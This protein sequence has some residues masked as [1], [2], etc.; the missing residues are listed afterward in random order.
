MRYFGLNINQDTEMDI[1]IDGD[2]KLE[3]LQPYEL[4]RV[5]W[6]NVN[7]KLNEIEMKA[8][9]SINASIG[10]LDVTASPFCAQVSS[11]LQQLAPNATVKELILQAN[12]LRKLKKLEPLRLI[13]VLG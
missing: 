2:D 3:R 4:S 11:H 7:E 13:N 12:L 6:E 8:F 9:A 10:W 1:S 5:R